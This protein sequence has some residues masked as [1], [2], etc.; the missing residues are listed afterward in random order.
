MPLSVDSS[1]HGA[2]MSFISRDPKIHKNSNTP[3]NWKSRKVMRY[4]NSP[5]LNLILLNQKLG[6]SPPFYWGSLLPYCSLSG[7]IRLNTLSL[8]YVWS[9]WSPFYQLLCSDWSFTWYSPFL[10]SVF[11]FCPIFLQM[12]L[13]LKALFLF[14]ILRNGKAEYSVSLEDCLLCQFWFTTV[15]TLMWILH[16]FT[17]MLKSQR[18]QWKICM[19]GASVR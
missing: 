14:T 15:I 13:S 3:K 18:P 10:E 7:L 4:Q 8:W 5:H 17:K 12:F 16:G 11:G 9:W 19:I 1:I 2:K 6:C